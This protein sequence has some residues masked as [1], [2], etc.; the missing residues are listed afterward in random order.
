MHKGHQLPRP[1]RGGRINYIARI[2]HARTGGGFDALVTDDWTLLRGDDA[3]PPAS[4]RQR[5]G[6]HASSEFSA[7]LPTDWTIVT[8]FDETEDGRLLVD[9]PE[10]IFRLGKQ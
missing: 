3:F 8:P 5:T 4:I 1:P 9:N 2:D 6:A 7:D 10:R